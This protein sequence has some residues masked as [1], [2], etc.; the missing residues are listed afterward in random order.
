M[1]TAT[2][3]GGCQ[4]GAVRY[5]VELDLSQPVIACNCSMCGKSGTL[6]SFVPE[7]KFTLLSGE[8]NL[9]DY[10]FNTHAISHLFCKTCGIKS[11]ARGK[12]PDGSATAAVN[13]RCLDGVDLEALSVHDFDGASR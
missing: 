9:Q 7:S 3:Q 8:Q 10:R 2:H 6:L 1:A 4:C 12:A 11:F 5:Q 13:V